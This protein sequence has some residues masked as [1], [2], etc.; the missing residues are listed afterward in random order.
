MHKVIV[1]I[2]QELDVEKLDTNM[3]V[4]NTSNDDGRNCDGPGNLTDDCACTVQGWAGD[5]VSGVV[6]DLTLLVTKKRI[7]KNAR[8]W[9]LGIQVWGWK[10]THNNG[11]DDVHGDVAALKESK[12][13]WEVS[14]ISELGDEGE[15]GDVT[16]ISE[17]HV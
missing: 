12:S 4:D 9:T 17:D 7:G 3:G 16:S 2:L 14:G 10:S 13:L 11:G 8:Q 6:V 15:E 1:S 5:T